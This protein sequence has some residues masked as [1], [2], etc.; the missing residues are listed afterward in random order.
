MTTFTSSL[1]D[2]ILKKLAEASKE[3][4]MPKNKIIEKALAIYFEELDKAA[5]KASFKRAA[6][7]NDMVAMAEEGM[8]DYFEMLKEFDNDN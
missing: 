4:K 3:L 2:D 1:P 8:K 7:D 6:K 5:Y